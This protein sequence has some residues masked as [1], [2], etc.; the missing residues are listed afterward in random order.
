MKNKKIPD[1]F[2]NPLRAVIARI[3]FFQR[4]ENRS[5]GFEPG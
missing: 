4:T 5:F 1:I 3:E 2:D